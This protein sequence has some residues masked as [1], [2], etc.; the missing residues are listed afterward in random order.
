[1]NGYADIA[2]YEARYGA[3]GATEAAR[4]AV[5]LDDAALSVDALVAAYSIDVAEKG[6]ILKAMLCEY[7]H[8]RQQFG[9]AP[10][11]SSVTHQAGSFSETYSMRSE[12]PFDRW[13][14]RY[15]GEAL[16]IAGGGSATSAKIAI[17]DGTGAM[18]RDL[19]DW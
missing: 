5:Q 12:L 14:L 1:M 11:I 18:P 9:A 10:H 15:F 8:Y 6:A 17:H 19:N 16:G 13:A 7:V 4:V 2:D 3:L